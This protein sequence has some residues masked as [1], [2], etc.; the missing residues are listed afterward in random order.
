MFEYSKSSFGNDEFLIDDNKYNFISLEEDKTI[1]WDKIIQPIDFPS[2]Q[3]KIDKEFSKNQDDM[4]SEIWINIS[5]EFGII[6]SSKKELEALNKLG[7]N[8]EKQ[9]DHLEELKEGSTSI[10]IKQASLKI[11]DFNDNL[12]D[13]RQDKD[14][15]GLVLSNSENENGPISYLKKLFKPSHTSNPEKFK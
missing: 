1:S 7:E 2:F 13:Q 14:S 6:T 12:S 5:D 3:Y 8:I 11:L 9:E 15:S 4:H 10:Y